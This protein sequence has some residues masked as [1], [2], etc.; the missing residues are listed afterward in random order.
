MSTYENRHNLRLDQVTQDA[1]EELCQHLVTTK[2]NLMRKYIQEGVRADI[3]QYAIQAKNV[4]MSVH[5]LKK[6]GKDV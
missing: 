4:A 1:L 2:S 3:R 5:I 6:A